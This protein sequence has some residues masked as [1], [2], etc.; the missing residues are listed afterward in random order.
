[1]M[2]SEFTVMDDRSCLKNHQSIPLKNLSASENVKSLDI[3]KNALKKTPI[4]KI[5]LDRKRLNQSLT[6][7]M[8]QDEV[9]GNSN[10]HFK[11]SLALSSSPI[12]PLKQSATA[13]VTS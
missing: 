4:I 1:M 9:F 13:A 2:R 5:K 8:G 6:F 10:K 7:D 12:T 3:E 11:A